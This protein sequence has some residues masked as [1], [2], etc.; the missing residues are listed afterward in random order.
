M[1][2]DMGAKPFSETNQAIEN[3]VKIRDPAEMLLFYVTPIGVVPWE[4]EH[5]YPAQQ[6]IFPS[7][8][9][10]ECLTAAGE[11]LSRLL[12]TMEFDTCIWVSRETPMNVMLSATG[13]GERVTKVS[14]ISE[15]LQT[16]PSPRH[17]DTSWQKRMIAAICAFQWDVS[18]IESL[19][20]DELQITLSS[21]T[22]KIRHIMRAGKVLFTLV[23]TNGLLTPTYDG[24][25][26]LLKSGLKTDYRV[27][28][29][30]DAAPFVGEG[31]S[32]MTKFVKWASPHLKAGEEVLVIDSGGELLGSGKAVLNGGEMTAYQRGVAV[33]MRHTRR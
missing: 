24:G 13:L 3:E 28:V 6:T 15:L 33:I 7:N 17:P 31:K 12:N 19:G 1:V 21:S 26:L 4:L 32:V 22:G 8:V 23:P 20:L 29:D 27:V 14:R 5:V 16:L 30:D 10:S 11:R 25:R 2:P 9:D 18:D